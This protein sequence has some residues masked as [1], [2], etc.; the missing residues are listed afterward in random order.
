[1]TG[2]R[3][4][5]ATAETLAPYR[6]QQRYRAFHHAQQQAMQPFEHGR[7]LLR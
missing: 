5:Q 7:A 4:L 1:V 6:R 3:N 2:K